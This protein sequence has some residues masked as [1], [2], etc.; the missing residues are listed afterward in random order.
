MSLNF[1]ISIENNYGMFS[2]DRLCF[3]GI[4]EA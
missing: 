4:D 1:I 2:I 3:G